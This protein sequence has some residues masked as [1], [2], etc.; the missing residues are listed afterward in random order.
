HVLRQRDGRACAARATGLAILD[1]PVLEREAE[2]MGEAAVRAFE[3]GDF[4]T[5][6]LPARGSS[7]MAPY[8][9]VIQ[10]VMELDDFKK[11]TATSGIRS[12]DKISAI[13]NELK[14][15]HVLNAK[16]PKNYTAMSKAAKKLYEAARTFK[17]Q[18][19]DS[20]RMPG[21]D[22]LIK[23]I[24]IE[25]AILSRLAEFEAATDELEKFKI[26]EKVQEN[27]FKQSQRSEL[28]NK[29]LD[30]EIFTLLQAFLASASNRG[31]AFV[32]R[33]IEELVEIGKDLKT[34]PLLKVVIAE[35]TAAR[36]VQLLDAAN[37]KPGLKF[38]TARGATQKYS[39][40]HAMEQSLGKRFRMGSLLHELTHLSIA[41][42]FDNTCLMLAV[43]TSATDAEIL[44]LAKSRN[45]KIQ[46]LIAVPPGARPAV[47]PRGKPLPPIPTVAG[48][49]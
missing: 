25:D 42:I 44:A 48:R 28:N 15:Y 32:K 27:F 3:S 41:E 18:K 17:S 35:C 37:G 24:V 45:S 16:K 19:P 47:A 40:S 11:Q 46:Q 39:L 30:G 14:A 34:P 9:P 8:S 7:S 36:N 12:L 22:Q 31:E 23:E 26:L 4:T 38:N 1:D 20:S 43:S 6:W 21:V 5:T 33:D 29:T 13:D 2:R 49:K 10:C